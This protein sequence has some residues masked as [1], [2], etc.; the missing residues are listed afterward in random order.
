VYLI[1][2]IQVTE[3]LVGSAGNNEVAAARGF[4]G[5]NRFGIGNQRLEWERLVLSNA[6]HHETEGIGHGQAHRPKNGGSFIFDTLIDA[7]APERP[8]VAVIGD[9]GFAMTGLELLTAVRENIPLTVIVFN[10]GYLGRIRL[11]QLATYGRTSSVR[12]QNPDFE[13]FALA[14]GARYALVEGEPEALL[15]ECVERPGVTLVEL[16]LGDGTRRHA[17]RAR[18]IVRN[19]ARMTIGLEVAKTLK[20]LLSR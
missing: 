8:V 10:D 18:G 12:L 5:L 13:A 11:E 19:V 20:R 14:V 1:S 16:R 15:R 7:G 6:H 9:G 2:R 17:V 4:H 3:K